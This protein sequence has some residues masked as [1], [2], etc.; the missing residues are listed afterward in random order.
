MC[1]HVWIFTQNAD[2]SHGMRKERKEE[3]KEGKDE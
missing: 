1:T 2:D 3:E